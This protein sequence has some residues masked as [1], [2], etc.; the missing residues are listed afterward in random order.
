MKKRICILICLLS[1]ALAGAGCAAPAAQEKARGFAAQ[2]ACARAL[3][4][5]LREGDSDA[6]LACFAI[7]EAARSFSLSAFFERF[8]ATPDPSNG[9]R[10]PSDAWAIAFN[11]SRLTRDVLNRLYGTKI[12]L[13]YPEVGDPVPIM[14]EFTADQ[15]MEVMHIGDALKNL[16]YRDMLDPKLF[17]KRYDNEIVTKQLERQSA[18]YGMKT[19]DEKI[20]VL[21]LDGRTLYMGA[22][23]VQYDTGWLLF[24]GGSVANA[25]MAV[26]PYSLMIA[27]EDVL[28]DMIAAPAKEAEE[29]GGK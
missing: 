16:S 6:F 11:E 8:G 25:L 19:Y 29:G 3:V 9:L 18:V 15:A 12:E 2:E 14:G 21:D 23:F 1:L 20:L 22:G 17:L 26:G 4:Q 27:A 24:P 5:S 28:E 13:F 7:G 10:Q